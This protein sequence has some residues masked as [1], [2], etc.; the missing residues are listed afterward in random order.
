MN[1][2]TKRATL[3]VK[4]DEIKRAI[5]NEALPLLSNEDPQLTMA[6]QEVSAQIDNHFRKFELVT[7]AIKP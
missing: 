6:L 1:A 2:S 5:D 7:K 4:L 3:Q